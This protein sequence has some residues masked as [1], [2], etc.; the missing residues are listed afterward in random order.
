MRNIFA[1][2]QAKERVDSL[3]NIEVD[4]IEVMLTEKLLTIPE[5][6]SVFDEPGEKERLCVRIDPWWSS[7]RASCTMQT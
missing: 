7:Y 5:H 3:L 2:Q 6:E 4:F 1:W